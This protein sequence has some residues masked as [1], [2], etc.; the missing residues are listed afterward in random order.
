[1][2]RF[3]RLT[4]A[5]TQLV[6]VLLA[7][8]DG[9]TSDVEPSRGADCSRDS[10]CNAELVC[11]FG[12]CHEECKQARDCED[13]EMCVISENDV[14]VCLLAEEASCALNSECPSPLVCAQDL[15]CRNECG[16]DRDCAT[17]TQTCVQPGGVCAEP[18]D[19]VGGRL[20][21][22]SA[23][24]MDGGADA[25]MNEAGAMM[26]M[27]ASQD[28]ALP[29]NDAAQRS[30]SGGPVGGSTGSDAS[31][32][33]A[34]MT[35]SG[36][37]ATYYEDDSGDE[38]QE[39][40]TREQALPLPTEGSLNLPVADQDWFWF[41][42][43]DDGKAHVLEIIVTLEQPTRVYIEAYAAEDNSQIGA[44]LQPKGTT[45]STFI[46]AGPNARTL[47]LFRAN[48]PGRL[49]FTWTMT[50]EIDDFEPNN[51]RDNV[52]P[53]ELGA[54]IEAQ[55]IRPHVSETD[56]D[57]SDWYSVELEPGTLTFEVLAV[58]DNVGLWVGLMN[59]SN[60]IARMGQHTPGVI[61]P[62]TAA[63]PTAGVYRL[64]VTNHSNS[65]IH[66]FIHGEKP[67]HL[68]ESYRFRVT[69]AP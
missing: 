47:V 55:Q 4:I 15:S 33:D 3:H 66:A 2:P 6:L 69:S 27:D 10:D 5:S 16:T 26:S 9:R 58:P 68:T 7:C 56:Q 28:G 34:S 59:P 43:P 40:D 22:S 61:G 48:Q 35:D 51:D 37:P 38:P 23:M 65:P 18:E 46:T 24:S 53:I 32:P 20:R 44:V 1:M 62:F 19:I 60:A 39:N 30:D 25:A 54:E 13:G 57:L 21:L 45:A 41:D 63:I 42:T 17:E 12:R 29:Q 8:S 14:R 49:D 31:P 52:S 50:T 36:T 11:R 64:Q 67:A